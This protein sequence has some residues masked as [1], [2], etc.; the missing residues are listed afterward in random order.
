MDT[1]VSL[2]FFEWRQRVIDIK[3]N[4]RLIEQ[5]TTPDDEPSL[6]EALYSN[7]RVTVRKFLSQFLKGRKLYDIYMHDV[8]KPEKYADVIYYLITRNSMYGNFDESIAEVME[9]L[10]EER[11]KY[12]RSQE[13][14][15]YTRSSGKEM[16]AYTVPTKIKKLPTNLSLHIEDEYWSDPTKVRMGERLEGNWNGG[17]RKSK[18]KSKN[19]SNSKSKSKRAS[20]RR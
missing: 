6:Y 16:K 9:V 12:Y 20:K 11:K 3:E 19:K 13:H 2:E 18:R 1:P 8:D 14:P 5:I 17:T 15:A 4:G 7:N 10:S